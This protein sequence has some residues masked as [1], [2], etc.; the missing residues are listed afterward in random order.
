MRAR[1]PTRTFAVACALSAACA[2][3][4]LLAAGARPAAADDRT[5]RR[6]AEM[7]LPDPYLDPSWPDEAG[8]EMDGRDAPGKSDS[9]EEVPLGDELEIQDELR[10]LQEL[11]GE[12][13]PAGQASP[14]PGGDVASPAGAAAAGEA[15]EGTEEAPAE[16]EPY[17]PQDDGKGPDLDQRDPVEW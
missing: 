5:E 6:A 17:V 8:E 1:R 11:N 14:P 16:P 15:G 10:A 2:A 7:P 3:S 4:Q 9:V 12:T 13:P